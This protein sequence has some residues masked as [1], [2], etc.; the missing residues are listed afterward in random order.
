LHPDSPV[1]E[2]DLGAGVSGLLLGLGVVV[3]EVGND[4]KPLRKL[5]FEEMELLHVLTLLVQSGVVLGVELEEFLAR[6]HRLD[7]VGHFGSEF[8]NK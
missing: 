1:V 6:S 3:E 2:L 5:S 7:G 8:G 4:L